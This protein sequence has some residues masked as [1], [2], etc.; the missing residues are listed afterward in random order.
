[1]TYSE[2]E[3]EFTFAKNRPSALFFDELSGI[4]PGEARLLH[5]HVQLSL[6]AVINALHGMQTRSSDENS[7]CPSVKRVHCEKTKEKSVQIFTPYERS[8]I[9]VF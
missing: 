4:H 1:M 3:L 5:T 2:H 8:F 9:L 6:T 7:V